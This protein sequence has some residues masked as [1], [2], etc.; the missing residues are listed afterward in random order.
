[1]KA[2][3]RVGDDP[4]SSEPAGPNL[5]PYRHFS[6]DEWAKLRAD[7]PLTLTI[8]DLKRLQS[9]NDPDIP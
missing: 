3:T 1:M 4:F 2:L 7:T 6:R 5:S 8:D 9:L